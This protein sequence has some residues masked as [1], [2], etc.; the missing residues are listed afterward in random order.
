MSLNSI[1]IFHEARDF[2]IAGDVVALNLKNLNIYDCERGQV[3]FSR[4]DE[5]RMMVAECFTAHI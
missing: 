3:L 5:E 4:F 2:A 1:E